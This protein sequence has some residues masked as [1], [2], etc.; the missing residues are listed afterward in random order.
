[1]RICG[2]VWASVELTP[3]PCPQCDSMASQEEAMVGDY[4]SGMEIK[5][6]CEYATLCWKTFPM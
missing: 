5:Q 3:H 4:L 1:M 2:P 6:M